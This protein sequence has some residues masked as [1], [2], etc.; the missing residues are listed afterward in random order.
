MEAIKG[1]GYLLLSLLALSVAGGVL[2]ALLSFSAFI[3]GALLLF[4]VVYFVAYMIKE[5]FKPLP[6]PEN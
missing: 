4:F 5:Y 6:P 1:L 2:I 3:G